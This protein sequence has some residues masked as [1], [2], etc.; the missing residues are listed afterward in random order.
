[1]ARA[2]FLRL[3]LKIV[4]GALL[5]WVM[6]G[7]VARES[8]FALIG[9][10]IAA[11]GCWLWAEWRQ[12][13]PETDAWHANRR[14]HARAWLMFQAEH[15]SKSGL[16]TS[17]LDEAAIDQTL[18][19]PDIYADFLR[20][21]RRRADAD[22]L[23]D[24]LSLVVTAPGALVLALMLT[25]P[26]MSW[27]GFDRGPALLALAIG[28]ALY[29][30][31]KLLPAL[32]DR[33]R[34]PLRLAIT[35]GV[36]FSAIAVAEARHPYLLMTGA[37]HRR[38]IAERVWDLG[39]T[40][41]SARHSDHLFAYARD[42]E[43]E[44]RWADATTVYQRGLTLD[45]YSA[46]AHRGLARALDALGRSAEAADSRLAA[47]Y[48]ENPSDIHAPSAASAL[49]A[50]ADSRL[51]AFDWSHASKHRICLVP[52]GDVSTTLLARAGAGL[53]HTLGVEV[54]LWAEEPP[55][56]LPAP[57]RR[58]GLASAPQ[59]E[60]APLLRELFAR[61]HSE[62]SGG[63]PFPGAWQFIVVTDVDLYLPESNYAFAASS[64]AHGV[65]SVARFG[66]AAPDRQVARLQK[67]LTSTAIKCFGVRQSTRPDCVTAYVRDLTE[68]DRRSLKPSAETLS[69]YRRQVSIW[70]S[71][72]AQPPPRLAE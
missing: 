1:M 13:R 27:T 46:D 7:Q 15:L 18:A 30:S 41:G 25:S 24:A 63:R 70:E 65:V 11:R 66:S 57:G 22:L 64:A 36:L 67:Q 72:P 34:P 9:L 4:L 42:L 61:L 69:A 8:L 40:I 31:P 59:W 53:A 21:H 51:P 50:R 17:P 62:I 23:S 48:L 26:I 54:F 55:L 10:A 52:I 44:G 6:H 5:A 2:I 12:P 45:A 33:A 49:D 14:A 39:V 28:A 35:A 38:V 29:F 16:P 20:T 58:L 19:H 43:N 60:P 47:A 37:E 68:L 71:N 56:P 3:L 32:A